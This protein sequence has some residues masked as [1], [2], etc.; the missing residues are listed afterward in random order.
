[1]L[2]TLMIIGSISAIAQNAITI[3]PA[4]T[5]GT[6]NLNLG[7]DS[8]QFLPGQKT[9][10]NGYNGSYLGPTLILNEGA[11]ANITVTNNLADTTTTHWHGLH[12]SADNDG[13]PH[14]MILPNA[15]WN[16][17]FTV[18][19]KAAT[20][21]YH[22]HLHTKTGHQV[23]KGAA[24]L[25]IVKD[26]VEA[27]LTLP[28]TYG[29]DDF[30]IIVQTQQLDLTNQVEEDGMRDSLTMVNG[31]LDPMVDMPAQVVRLRILNADQE[32]NYR[33]GFTASKTF[34]IIATDGGLLSA[35]VNLTRIDAAPGERSE[36]LLDLTGMNGQTIYLMSYASEIPYGVQGG[37][38]LK[39]PN[40]M[41]MPMMMSPLNGV[42]YNVLKINVVAPTTAPTPIST[43]PTALATVT[44]IPVASVDKS[45]Q[46]N[47]TAMMGG[48]PM[49]MMDGPFYFNDSSFNMNRM[50]QF[51]QL[52]DVE[53]WT[54]VNETMVAHPFHIHDVQFFIL[55]IN[56]V[57]PAPEKAG[58]KDVVSVK[59]KDTVRFITIFEDFSGLTP[60]MYHCHNLMHEDGG[61][62]GQFV[63]SGPT[64]VNDIVLDDS[65]MKL[66]PN[67]ATKEITVQIT[68]K[69]LK[70][71]SA[72]IFDMTGKK[73]LEVNPDD[74]SNSLFHIDIANLPPSQYV[75]SINTSKG[76]IIKK[77][78][79]Q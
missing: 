15:S 34:D 1:M 14:S 45:R 60:Y 52:N 10:T 59:S 24:G 64:A 39:M 54:L 41:P 77:M 9:M 47:F 65:Y 71:Q 49:Q 61:M 28:R 30:P 78:T 58:R 20:Y 48:T 38:H 55:D 7:P 74:L 5:G 50:D 43:I 26:A 70:V 12:V 57:P 40:N 75:I 23:M 27:A 18:M 13:G 51:V 11:T 8:V 44:P 56:G 31:T 69:D 72:Y 73:I 66:Y 62:M 2:F 4:L 25:I 29:V 67:P 46:I 79:K 21:W 22:P 68:D 63:V 3:P 37:P 33:F 6:Y 16:P 36:I 42:D 53:I 32:R 35:P 17:T 76:R 19:D